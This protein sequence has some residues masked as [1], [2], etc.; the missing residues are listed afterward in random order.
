MPPG[1]QG[2]L[3]MSRLRR[4]A[5]RLQRCW[6]VYLLRQRGWPDPAGTLDWLE[7]RNTVL[8]DRNGHEQ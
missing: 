2:P 7:N 8:L 6:Y 3:S 4:L 5:R 1:A